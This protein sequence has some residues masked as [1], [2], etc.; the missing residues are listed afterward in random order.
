M[1]IF[2]DEAG[3]F[4]T[5]SR[6]SLVSCVAALLVPE[7]L[8][9]TLFRKFRRVTRPWR[10]AAAEAKGSQLS[11][12]QIAEVISVVRRFDVLLIAVA[13]DM[14]LHSEAGISRHK[15]DQVAKLA[16]NLS[17]FMSSG[18]RAKVENLASRMERLSTQLY[19]QS[20]LLTLL[21]QS[22]LQ[23][24]TLYYVQRIPR[25]L[26]SFVWRPDAKDTRI[27]EY[28]RLW[29][30]I[31]GPFL[32]TMSIS[33][34]LS[35]LEGADYSAFSKYRGEMAEVPE[36]L[37]EHV[38]RRKRPFT[39]INLDLVLGDLKFSASHRLTGIQIVDTL[40]AAVR[41]ACNGTLQRTGW[42]GLG[43]LMPT[44][45]RDL[46]CIQ[47][48]ALEDISYDGLPYSGIIKAWNLETKRLI[49]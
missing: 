18:M 33:S 25:T 41:R 17:P 4:Q 28:E 29:L 20:L 34:P 23:V 7:G 19:V 6:S 13:I 8:A 1:Y 12:D 43:R 31:V 32:E 39:Y 5:P 47:F 21:V 48:V 35:E 15:K 40:A 30:E 14:G 11:E 36:H 44:P 26:G 42:K 10:V 38:S 9:M 45:A 27:T 49:I 46:D 2:I 3:G 24:G 16:E 22:V 37:R